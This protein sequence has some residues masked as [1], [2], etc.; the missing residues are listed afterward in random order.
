MTAFLQRMTAP[1]NAKGRHEYVLK[2]CDVSEIFWY[3]PAEC[4]CLWFALGS[5]DTGN[6]VI[7]W[8][9]ENEDLT[10]SG[11]GLI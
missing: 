4:V 6:S 1:N 11:R 3:L 7:V 10:G 2:H 5:R 9:G 8:F